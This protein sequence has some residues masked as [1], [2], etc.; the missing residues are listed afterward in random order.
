MGLAT[1][2][3]VLALGAGPDHTGYAIRYDP[4]V[5]ERMADVR[6]IPRQPCMVA[7]TLARDDDMGR[8]WLRVK[9]P[10]GT[11]D[12]LVVDLPD[13]SKR[14]RQPLIDRGVIVELGWPSHWICGRGWTGKATECPVKV[15]R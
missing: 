3:L 1:A 11:L 10:V 5:M 12:C 7:Y 15:W 13:D 2:A 8:L 9:G 4:G 14:H 6:G